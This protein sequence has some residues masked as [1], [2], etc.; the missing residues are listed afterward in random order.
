VRPGRRRLS[1]SAIT[2]A[3]AFAGSAVSFLA[4]AIA[5][6]RAADFDWTTC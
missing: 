5:T 6:T 1:V 2:R 3:S 4:F